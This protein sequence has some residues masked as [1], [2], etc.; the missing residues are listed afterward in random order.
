MNEF[1]RLIVDSRY[2]TKHSVSNSDFSVDLS[3]PVQVPRN[4]KVYVDTVTFSNVFGTVMTG[5]NDKLYVKERLYDTSAAS[6]RIYHRYVVL[7]PGVYTIDQMAT[8]VEDRL[9][10]NRTTS[11]DEYVI[12]VRDGFLRFKN[13]TP[14]ATGDAMIYSRKQMQDVDLN[15]LG[16][17]A[18]Y[19]AS[20][21]PPSNFKEAF[22]FVPALGGN[23]VAL[24]SELQDATELIGL[25]D[26][27]LVVSP[28]GATLPVTQPELS[29]GSMAEGQHVDLTRFKNLFLCTNDLGEGQTLH[30]DGS[31][32][33]IRRVPITSSHG[34][35]VSDSLSTLIEY[36]TVRRDL[37]LTQL[38]FQVKG[39]GGEI[40]PM[41]GHEIVFT[42][43]I[44]PPE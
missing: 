21:N 16:Y 23:T 17:Y 3:Q 29:F 1:R 4:S 31:T 41:G 12:T 11:I 9:N 36:N 26:T 14:L 19:P 20:A 8:Q 38:H 37:L 30:V 42:I 7:E 33:I 27:P 2:K 35:V 34:T 24:P 13:I 44:E 32:D 10:E 15:Y 28:S 40:I 43:V 25:I 39:F 5:V 6:Y 18:Q 22:A